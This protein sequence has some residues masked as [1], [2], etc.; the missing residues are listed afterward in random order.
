[1][2]RRR[3]RLDSGRSGRRARP[4]AAAT[5]PALTPRSLRSR[6]KSCCSELRKYPHP[7]ACVL[8]VLYRRERVASRFGA[9]ERVARNGAYRF[10]AREC[11][12]PPHRV[13]AVAP[14][15][16]FRAASSAQAAA[17]QASQ[18]RQALT[19]F[20]APSPQRRCSRVW[21]R[22][23]ARRARGRLRSRRATLPRAIRRASS[24][25]RRGVRH[26]RAL[27]P[28]PTAGV[29][30]PAAESGPER[31]QAHARSVWVLN[32]SQSFARIKVLPAFP[33]S[34]ASHG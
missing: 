1:M 18:L 29:L 25:R 5:A 19:L 9:R 33:K 28:T 34:M 6:L 2:Q 11:A 14:S 16:R 10:G 4:S 17:Q 24:A 20:P 31:T 7:T 22:A 15:T 8:T 26:S 21:R 23:R 27:G 32:P 13:A 30:H 12:R 3:G